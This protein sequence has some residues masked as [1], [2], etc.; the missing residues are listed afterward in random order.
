VIHASGERAYALLARNGFD[1]DLAATLS[2]DGAVAAD[3]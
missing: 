1:L 3:D 2:R